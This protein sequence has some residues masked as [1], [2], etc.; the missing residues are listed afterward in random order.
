MT[1]AIHFVPAAETEI[2]L[3]Y[4]SEEARDAA[5]DW[6]NNPKRPK[7]EIIAYCESR[8]FSLDSAEDGTL[9]HDW[10]EVA[11]MIKAWEDALPAARDML[12]GLIDQV[13]AANAE[14]AD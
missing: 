8:G 4:P 6:Y 10:A 9:L 12:D 3:A 1:N 14:L 13:R 7:S 5:M 2:I 11:M